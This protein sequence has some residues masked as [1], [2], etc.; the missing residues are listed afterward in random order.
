KNML[1]EEMWQKVNSSAFLS[2]EQHRDVM[3]RAI[4]AYSKIKTKPPKTK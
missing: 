4:K 1:N 2:N 3:N